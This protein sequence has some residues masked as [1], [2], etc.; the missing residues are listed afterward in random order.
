MHP[1]APVRYLLSLTADP[2]QGA[3]PVHLQVLCDELQPIR[4]EVQGIHLVRAPHYSWRAYID[5]SAPGH[6]EHAP[7]RGAAGELVKRLSWTCKVSA[8]DL[9]VRGNED[10]Q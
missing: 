3:P 8:V 7:A 6:S 5:L 4:A 9:H 2:V 10:D 1:A